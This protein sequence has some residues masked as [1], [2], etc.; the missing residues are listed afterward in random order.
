MNHIYRLVWNDLSNAWVAV[1]EIARGR[2]KRSGGS[3]AIV[4]H[5]PCGQRRLSQRILA[6]ALAVIGVPAWGLDIN[7]LPSGGKVVAGAATISQA[8]N[9][10]T[11]QQASQRAALDWQSFNIGA[12][13]TVN[14]IQPSSSAVAL[15]RIVGNEASQI[16]GK[17]NANGQVFFSNPNGMLFARGAQVNVGGILA[18]TMK[19]GNDDFMAGNYRLSNP[20]GGSII[21][22]G[23][24]N[25]L[26]SVALIGNDVR[27]SGQLFATT[28]T[29]AAGNTVAVDLS[30]DGLIRARVEDAALKAAIEN[31]GSI[32]TTAAVTLTA[33]QAKGALERVV[34]N[35]GVIRAIGLTMKGGEILLEA[36]T[37]EN[38]GTIVASGAKG[39]GIIKLMGDMESGTVKV[40]GTL[41]ASAAL[42]PLQGEGRGGDGANRSA[43]G[44]FIETSAAHVK[45]ADNAKVTTAAPKGLAGMWLIDPVDFT[46]A[47][48][49]GDMTGAALTTSLASTNVSI[50]STSGTVGTAGDVNVNDA[51]S[52]AANKLTLNAQNNININ[53]NLNGSGSA[54]LALDFGQQAEAAGNTSTYKVN[55]PV[56]LPAVNN[57]STRLGSD[58]VVKNYTVITSL[59]AAGS[60][61]ATDLQGMSGNLAGNYVLGSDIDASAT[62]EWNAGAGFAPVGSSSTNFT[63]VL[64]GLGHSLAGL[65]INRPLEDNVGLIG[66]A[67]TG[68]VI[69]NVRLV[70]G[71]VT[72]QYQVGSLVGF[73]DGGAV[74]NS[75]ATGSVSG[76]DTVGGLVGLN[77]T[78][79]VS[80]SR[81]TG[82]VSGAGAGNHVGGLVG[83]NELSGTISNS[84][85]TGNVTGADS[86]GGLVG[87]AKTAA[88]SAAV[89]PQAM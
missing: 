64:D 49:G 3:G 87:S 59:G 61:T 20:G 47:A 48:S 15:N 6:A 42:P 30:G 39:G 7:A 75:Y 45:I 77:N 71:S 62:S 5:A 36:A 70:G 23:L 2:G 31:S 44:G 26:G 10:L 80:N 16:Y 52:W 25:A 35:T 69:R 85:A 38:T 58:G 88:P 73:N 40:G 78:G 54:Q 50:L 11:V 89:T 60:T 72:G 21:N 29:L 63:G 34:N 28:V 86:V 33:N 46:I 1:A 76:N 8:A 83:T 51:V 82:N 68:S 4:G 43:N 22:D 65:T 57:F 24:I 84:Y 14:F 53:A 13:A 27:N 74:S 55:A 32:D 66:H 18:T 67:G 17:L 79:T 37:V 9:V 41:D 56:N 19:L 81:A 12:A